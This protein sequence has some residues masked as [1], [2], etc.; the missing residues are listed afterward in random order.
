MCE[1]RR[2]VNFEVSIS[3]E[4]ETLGGHSGQP[5]EYLES[6]MT[7]TGAPWERL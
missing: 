3:G 7:D 6:V 2:S 5:S 1:R 4:C